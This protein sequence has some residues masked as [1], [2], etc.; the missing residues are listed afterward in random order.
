MVCIYCGSKTEVTNSRLQK[1]L[2][3]TWRRRACSN[4]N[5]VFTTLEH[6]DLA[7]SIVVRKP[8]KTEP[9]CRDKLFISLVASLGHRSGAVVEAGALAG[10]IINQLL[11]TRPGALIEVRDIAL[12]TYAVLE[13][14]D[15]AAATHYSAY[16]SGVLDKS[17]L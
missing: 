17:R 13:R 4:C 8:D 14:Y 7:A 9:F 5:T 3:Q 11:R 16:H 2:N 6:P 15:A 1:R 12:E 10:T